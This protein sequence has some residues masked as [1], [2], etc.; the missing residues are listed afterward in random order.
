ME[1]PF[2]I[3]D[4]TNIYFNYVQESAEEI[5]MCN[6][7]KG[8]EPYYVKYADKIKTKDVDV[9]YLNVIFW[10]VKKVGDKVQVT[11]VNDMHPGGK[12]LDM[13]KNK[14]PDRQAK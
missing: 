5:M 10:H 14:M 7:T 13:M 4:K 11:H 12:I 9:S 1:T 6:T 3:N 2:I 8:V